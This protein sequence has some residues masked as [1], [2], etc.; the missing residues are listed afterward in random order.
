MNSLGTFL[1]IEMLKFNKLLKK[2]ATS[3]TELQRAIKGTTATHSNTLQYTAIHCN[4]LQLAATHCNTL[5]LTA[6]HATHCN[7][8]QQT[9]TNCNT[10]NTL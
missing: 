8:L 5:Q 10:R 7:T 3:L 4:T 2:M 6:A 1:Q 9:A